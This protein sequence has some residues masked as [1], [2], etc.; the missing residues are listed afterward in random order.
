MNELEQII[1][2][3]KLLSRGTELPSEIQDRID[4]LPVEDSPLLGLAKGGET[5]VYLRSLIFVGPVL[6]GMARDNEHSYLFAAADSGATGTAAADHLG[7]LRLGHQTTAGGM[8]LATGE[9]SSENARGLHQLLPW[10]RPRSL[11]EERTTIGMGDRLGIATP[12]HIRAARRYAISPVLAQQ[13]VRENDFIGRNYEDVVAN[14][15]WGVFQEGFRDGYGADGDHLKTIPAIDTALDAA[16]PMITLD[17]TEV[18]RPE[19]ADWTDGEVEAQFSELDETFRNRVSTE[20]AGKTFTLAGDAGITVSLTLSPEDARR[21]A[22]MYGPALAF[23]R[24]VNDHL[25]QATGGAYDLEISIDETTTPTIPEHHLFI[26]RELQHRGVLVNSLAPRFIGEFQ[27]AIDYI[28]DVQEFSEQFRVHCLIARNFGGYKV[29]VHSGSDKFAVYPV[30]GKETGMRLHLK[31]SGTSWLEA[32][33]TIAIHEPEFYRG[34]HTFAVNYYPTALTHYHITADFDA[35]PALDS[36]SD[37]ELPGYLENPHARQMLHISYGGILQDK[38][39]GPELYRVL[40]RREEEYA[41]QLLVH[42]NRHIGGL[43]AQKR[44]LMR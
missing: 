33:R 7:E 12:G 38:N 16:M 2:E 37:E 13:S 23:S 1:D 21:C 14:A 41:R 36:L 26:A 6:L 17:L 4:A 34:V 44:E 5:Q 25:D 27:K 43:G 32:L 9:R 30:V 10:T 18:M 22:V 19:V 15:T 28:G 40:H 35:I 11:R 3:F 20:Y 42:F 31:T 39:L 29:S 24:D 8:W